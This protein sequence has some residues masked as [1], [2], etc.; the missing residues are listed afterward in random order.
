MAVAG[1]VT[2]SGF[3]LVLTFVSP[4]SITVTLPVTKQYNLCTPTVPDN[5]R[6]RKTSPC[7]HGTLAHLNPVASFGLEIVVPDDSFGIL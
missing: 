5:P 7:T 4:L 1:A 2:I 3:S 6:I